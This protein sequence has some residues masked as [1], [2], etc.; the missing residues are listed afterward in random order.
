MLNFQKRY[1]N[2][3][4]IVFT[5]NT[6]LW[7]LKFLKSGFRHCYVLIE[8][9]ENQWLEINPMSNQL[10]ISVRKI[11]NKE[12]YFSYLR[13]KSQAKIIKTRIFQAPLKTAP[14]GVFSCVEMIKRLVGIHSFFTI[15]PYRLYNKLKIVGKKS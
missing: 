6:S 10:F 3:C 15:T 9:K 13:K 4:Y 2:H 8:F 7:W 11:E 12:D 14:I 1:I 5:D